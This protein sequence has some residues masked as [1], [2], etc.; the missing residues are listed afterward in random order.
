MEHIAHAM[1][2]AH[3]VVDSCPCHVELLHGSHQLDV[4]SRVRRQWESCP[5]RTL[6]A[7]EVSA[8]L[9][10]A[11]LSVILGTSSAQC[12][13][14]M[15]RDIGATTRRNL[16]QEFELARTHICFYCSVKLAHF[17]DMPW[18]VF[19]I[20]HKNPDISSRALER[21]LVSN[22]PHPRLQRLRTTLHTQALQWLDGASL[23]E[24]R[25]RDL[26]EF[27]AELRFAPVS[28]RPGE[29]FHA[30]THKRG[31]AAPRHTEQLQSFMLQSCSC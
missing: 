20:A 17:G 25:M 9:L 5:M 15:P 29:S 30:M 2:Q 26:A 7:P 3:A 6:L 19:Q 8:G 13:A 12:V 14:S 4:S 18:C 11:K 24:P 23:M 1:R 10:Q 28:D 16:L 27:V 22:S 21:C 31:R